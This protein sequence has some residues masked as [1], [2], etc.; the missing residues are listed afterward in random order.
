MSVRAVL[1]AG[2]ALLLAALI[3]TLSHAEPRQAGTNHVPEIE[4]V[5]KRRGAWEHCQS[6][7][8]VP[9]DAANLRLLVGTYGRPTPELRVAARRR[10][11]EVVTTGRLPAGGSEGHIQIPVRRVDRTQ[12]GTRVCVSVASRGR[13]VLYGAAGRLRLDWYR[14]G[15]ESWFELLPAVAHRFGLAR[16]NPIGSFLLPVA[17]VIL[18]LGWVATARL[19][20]REVGQ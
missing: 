17:G 9:R 16:A 5:A 11:G 18:L 15:S 19:I 14:E 10:G 4:E 20:V 8:I 6:G 1:A 2:F 13:T 3:L 7:E 12:G